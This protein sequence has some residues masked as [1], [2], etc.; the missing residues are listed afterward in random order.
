MQ[1]PMAAAGLSLMA[2]KGESLEP[3]KLEA[4]D[5]DA[6]AVVTAQGRYFQMDAAF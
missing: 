5:A 3:S 2:M 6:D 1:S 4:V